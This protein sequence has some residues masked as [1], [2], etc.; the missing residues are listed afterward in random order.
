MTPATLH[1]GVGKTLA[2]CSP[3][4]YEA[5]A[6]A[7][8]TEAARRENLRVAALLATR[9]GDLGEQEPKR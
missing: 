2:L 9:I 5:M 6:R 1:T 3:E 8:A 4:E 7:C